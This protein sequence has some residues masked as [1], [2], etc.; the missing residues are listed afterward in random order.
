VSRRTQLP[1]HER[2]QDFLP[3]G[4]LFANSG[5]TTLCCLNEGTPEEQRSK[6]FLRLAAFFRRRV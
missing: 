6:L 4:D 2:S 5:I 1:R 3:K